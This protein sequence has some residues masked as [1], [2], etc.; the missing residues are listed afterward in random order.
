MV[1][2]TQN[3]GRTR[4]LFRFVA[5]ALALSVSAGALTIL[6]VAYGDDIVSAL[7]G[8]ADS[9]DADAADGNVISS[10]EVPRDCSP[11]P[12]TST[13]PIAAT[14]PATIVIELSRRLNTCADRVVLA[15]TDPAARWTAAQAAIDSDAVYLLAGDEPDPQLL[16]ELNRLAPEEVLLVGAPPATSATLTGDWEFTEQPAD[17]MAQPPIPPD[18]DGSVLWSLD[19]ADPDLAAL[20]APAATR[21][22]AA[23]VE[24]G[25]R[26][27]S[28]TAPDW[29]EIAA[30]VVDRLR[31]AES[32]QLIGS[33]S[34]TDVW[35]LGAL[36][37]GTE[38][39]G[40]GLTIGPDKRYIAFY[41]APGTSLLGVLGEQDP[42]AT[43]DRM[44]PLLTE[45]Q[46]DDG[47]VVVPTFELIATVAAAD[48]GDDGDYSN[49]TP[50]AA[51]RPYVD[52]AAENGVYVLLDLQPGRTDF[53]TQ[54]K[55]YEELLT[56]PHVGLALDPEWRLAPDQR[57]LRQLGSVD[58][59]EINEVSAW[60]ADLVRQHALPQKMLLIHQFNLSMVTNRSAIEER[61][62]L[63]VVIQMDGQGPLGTKYGTLAALVRGTE[64]GHWRWGW[65]NF[66]D[67]DAP[68]ATPA[69]TLAVDPQ[70]VY[71]SYQ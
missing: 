37:S 55:R 64:D 24:L 34:A 57:H 70:P 35:Q 66:Y 54:A 60:L 67:E 23:V 38:L 40:G 43:L 47:V 14:D 13:E 8:A 61:P 17:P 36:R 15:G 52:H 49:E 4:S 28:T 58:A 3:R 5:L 19:G 31:A 53:L 10:T 11:Q 69:Q 42:A 65:K 6:A 7:L 27:G 21:A 71:V 33:F 48:A 18:G 68:M 51:L 20:L 39:P 22:R 32:M 30:E 12:P 50:V 29:F 1:A 25:A 9:T 46:T 62:E 44:Q 26:A 63:S 45:Y 2:R 56:Q 41:G 59:A 16:A